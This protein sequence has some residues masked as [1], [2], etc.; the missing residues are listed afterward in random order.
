MSWS[1]YAKGDKALVRKKVED[2][3]V[4]AMP[5]GE[6]ETMTAAKALIIAEIE[7]IPA[8]VKFINVEAAGS[9]SDGSRTTSIKVET[10]Y[11]FLV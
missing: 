8:G 9:A 10:L 3:P 1:I 2:E 5:H 11:G 6:S 7:R 4:H